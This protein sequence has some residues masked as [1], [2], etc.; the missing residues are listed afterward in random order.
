[1]NQVT[2]QLPAAATAP[3]SFILYLPGAA[4]KQNLAKSN[5]RPQ[6]ISLPDS[7]TTLPRRKF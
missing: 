4:A 2:Y 1:M 6:F 7:Y 5:S 3:A